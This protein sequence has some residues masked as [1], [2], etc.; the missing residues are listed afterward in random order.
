MCVQSAKN[1][2]ACLPDE[3]ERNRS[4][5]YRVGPWWSTV[6][7]IVQ[8]L[9]ILVLEMSLKRTGDTEGRQGVVAAV[10]KLM[11]W[12]TAMSYENAMAK[13]ARSMM[14]RVLHDMSLRLEVVCALALS[15]LVND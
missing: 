15:A 8:S 12:L 11:S 14:L 7:T 1:F 2:S 5:M 10:K 4:Q 6:H 9:T 13:R 3:P